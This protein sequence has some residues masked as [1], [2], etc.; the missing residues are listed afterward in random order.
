MS[1]TCRCTCPTRTAGWIPF[2]DDMA[3]VSRPAADASSG[4]SSMFASMASL[5]GRS[6]ER[7]A[8]A[9]AVAGLCDGA[10]GQVVAITG[11]P[12]I[13]KSRLLAEL[14]AEATE[15]LVLGAA[16]SEF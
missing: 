10:A 4:G 6:S 3:P 1:E 5:V 13:G 7:A 14:A 2:W 16:A 9:A 12:G 15:C 11:E 8:L